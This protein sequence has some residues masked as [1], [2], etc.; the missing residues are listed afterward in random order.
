MGDKIFETQGDAYSWCIK[1]C[2]TLKSYNTLMRSVKE[3]IK[4][5]FLHEEK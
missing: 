1:L 3:K 2:F 4:R 5:D